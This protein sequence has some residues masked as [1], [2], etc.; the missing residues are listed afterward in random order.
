MCDRAPQQ[1]RPGK[2]PCSGSAVA[3]G[4]SPGPTPVC[5]STQAMSHLVFPQF[6]QSTEATAN[7]APF[8][9]LLFLFPSLLLAPLPLPLP[10]QQVGPVLLHALCTHHRP[11]HGRAIDGVY[12]QRLVHVLKQGILLLCLTMEVG[13]RRN[14]VWK[15]FMVMVSLERCV[16]LC[17]L[18]HTGSSY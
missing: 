13:V 14:A 8:C 3:R 18:E 2:Q 5:W 17:V 10:S 11:R 9:T 7:G 12:G 4:M 16:T 15:T 6:C 1:L